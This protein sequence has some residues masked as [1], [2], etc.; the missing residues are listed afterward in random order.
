MVTLRSS[1]LDA[2]FY[3]LADPARRSIVAR[4]AKGEAS[5]GQLAGPMPMSRPAVS[6]HLR[7]LVRAG[8]VGQEKQGRVRVCRL[9][10]Q[11]LKRASDWCERYHRFWTERLDDLASLLESADEDGGASE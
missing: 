4:L 7:I 11:P 3:A 2:V 1:G 6:K 9:R 8:L 10:R 5:V